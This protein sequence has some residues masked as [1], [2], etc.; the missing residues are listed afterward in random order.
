MSDS[1]A[2]QS[3]PEEVIDIDHGKV[4]IPTSLILAVVTGLVTSM[5]GC[6]AAVF[7]NVKAGQLEVAMVE[8]KQN[9]IDLARM[10]ERVKHIEDMVE[11][12]S[13]DVRPVRD[14]R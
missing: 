7:Q 10:D 14:S 5:G 8:I 11:R 12:L 1:E 3:K 9:Q 13:E 2:S 6:T 4:K